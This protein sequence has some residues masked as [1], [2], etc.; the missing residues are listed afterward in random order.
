LK[1][2]LHR[3]IAAVAIV[4]TICFSI[5]SCKI[6]SGDEPI[7]PSIPSGSIQNSPSASKDPG[8]AASPDISGQPSLQ[9][10]DPA[11]SPVEFTPYPDGSL[12]AFAMNYIIESLLDN[13]MNIHYYFAN[14]ETYGFPEFEI[15]WGDGYAYPSD[16]DIAR[17]TEV[18]N[19]V[20]TYDY[21]LLSEDEQFVYNLMV[22]EYEDY[23]TYLELFYYQ[24]PLMTGIGEH[25]NLPLVLAEY[26]LQKQEDIDD[27]ITLIETAGAYYDSIAEFERIKSAQGLF[28]SDTNL[29]TVLT[30]CRSFIE[31]PES[32]MLISSFADN[33][34]ALEFEIS[35]EMRAAYIERNHNAVINVI[36]PAYERLIESLE[37][38]RGSGVN[39]KGL[40][41]LP[42][43]AEYAAYKLKTFGIS[44]SPEQYIKILEERFDEIYIDV[45]NLITKNPDAYADM[46]TL[47][48][49]DM[50]PVETV[51]FL[52]EA[53]KNDFPELPAGTK[54]TIKS[55]DPS[56]EDAARPAMY[57]MPQIDNPESNSITVNNKYFEND[58]AYAFTT[59]A[60]EG[61]PGHLQQFAGI[62]SQNVHPLRMIYSYDAN[63][64]GWATYAEHY[65]AKYFDGTEDAKNLYVLNNLFY[66]ILEARIEMG[67]SYEGWDAQDTTDYLISALGQDIGPE[68]YE[69]CRD[70]PMTFAQYVG[71]YL[72]IQILRDKFSS[73]DDL[74]FHTDF[75]H[76][77]SVPFEIMDNYLSKIYSQG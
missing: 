41:G 20:L 9:S 52:R 55:V 74:T 13:T 50:S 7:F 60:H 47:G 72:E 56:Q 48:Y 70:T 26:K 24:E 23:K 63:S 11:P 29:D 65:A 58:P 40:A 21:N 66:L 16:Q 75:L 35:D 42:R 51:A 57:F 33:I 77:G 30:E 10:P 14:P 37:A 73:V 43:G 68:I 38:L 5:V 44:L 4:I 49:P 62:R 6:K 61:Y 28:M 39:G 19:T 64:E 27:Y 32:N 59:L 53:A 22:Y 25:I 71:G 8:S 1:S 3:K 36:I 45:V 15:S 67:V 34:D 12:S 69:Y 2:T 17:E 46:E 54:Y 76:A 18:F 31:N